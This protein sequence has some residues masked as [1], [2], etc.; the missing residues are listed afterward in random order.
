VD[1]TD[2]HTERELKLRSLA[3]T[4]SEIA[5]RIGAGRGHSVELEGRITELVVPVPFSG[6]STFR[7]PTGRARNER[8]STIAPRTAPR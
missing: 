7:R 8:T 1:T 2:D 5:T 6:K 4:P 3:L